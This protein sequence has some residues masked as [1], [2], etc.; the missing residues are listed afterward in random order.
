MHAYV[1]HQWGILMFS[2]ESDIGSGDQFLPD[3][4]PTCCSVRV[5]AN[6]FCCWITLIILGQIR[7]DTILK[8]KVLN[9]FYMKKLYIWILMS[10]YVLTFLLKG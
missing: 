7:V 1:M 6:L 10:I 4:D 8:K 3:S 5:N 9:I 2:T